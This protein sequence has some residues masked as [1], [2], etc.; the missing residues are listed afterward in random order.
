LV[1][2]PEEVEHL[3]DSRVNDKIILKWD[4]KISWEAVDWIHLAQDRDQWRTL[5]NTVMK[6]SFNIRESAL[7][8][9]RN[10]SAV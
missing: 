10:L 4:L 8:S 2:K 1:V 9:K 6:I 7:Y 3:E 5:A